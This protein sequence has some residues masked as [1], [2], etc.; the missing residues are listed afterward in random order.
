MAHRRDALAGVSRL[1]LAI[2]E[3]AV[4]HGGVCTVGS[5]VTRPG[6]VT[7][8]V[9]EA[10]LTLDQ[11]HLDAGTLARML[12]EARDA[13]EPSPPTNDRRRLAAD[14]A[15]PAL[16][17]PPRADRAGRRRRPRGLRRQLPPPPPGPLHDAAEVCRA[18]VPTV[19]LFVQSLRGISHNQIEDTRE[20]HIALSVR[21][22]DALARRTIAWIAAS[23]P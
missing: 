7:A 11:R 19:M 15:H 4:R 3:I 23:P 21:A 14:L 9:G 12:Q 13:S 10:T 16:P 8:V 20:D 2:R 18:G 22:L 1:H 6:I 5:V 17:L